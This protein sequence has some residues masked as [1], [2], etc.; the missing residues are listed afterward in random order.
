MQKLTTLYL[1]GNKFDSLPESM[2]NM[3]NLESLFLHDNPNLNIPTEILGD[4]YTNENAQAILYYYFRTL[5]ES[6]RPLHEAK[7]V[8]VGQGDVGKTTLV[9]RLIDEKFVETETTHGIIIRQW[10]LPTPPPTPPRQQ[11]GEQ[12]VS[13]SQQGEESLLPPVDGGIEGGIKLNIWDFGGQEI[14]HATH[15]FFMTKRTLYLVIWDARSDQHGQKVAYWLKLIRSFAPTSPIIVVC[16]KIDEWAGY[17]NQ[18]ELR[19]AYNVADFA[20]V[21]AMTGQV[22][23]N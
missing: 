19:T 13:H 7:L 18:G 10:E 22:F 12:K 6:A 15:Q 5:Q 20:Q 14:M 21:S 9:H 8:L 4:K 11:E 2:L 23:P 16:N 1:K 3:P 17:L